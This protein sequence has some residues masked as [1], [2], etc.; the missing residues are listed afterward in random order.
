ML[1][2]PRRTRYRKSHKLRIRKINYSKGGSKFIIGNFAIK[3]L[4]ACRL[5]FRPIEAGRRILARKL[6]KKSRIWIRPLAHTP[7]TK[8]PNEIRMGKGK[9]TVH[10]WV[11]RLEAGNIIFEVNHVKTAEVVQ[12]LR[13]AGKKLPVPSV[14]LE[15]REP[16]HKKK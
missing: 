7:L 10:S 8:K 13:N 4:K 6:K 9:G 12:V 16:R 2:P 1:Q 15:R 5:A 14:V 11:N 3:A